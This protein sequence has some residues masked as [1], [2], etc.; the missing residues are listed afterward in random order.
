MA[1][2]ALSLAITLL[3]AVGGTALASPESDERYAMRNLALG[4]INS[5]DEPVY[6]QTVE[7]AIV[8]HGAHGAHGAQGA[9]GAHGPGGSNGSRTE[10]HEREGGERRDGEPHEDEPAAP[11]E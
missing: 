10:L 3:L 5:G 11:V 4:V 7:A 2:A 9:H 8:A 6:A 1:A